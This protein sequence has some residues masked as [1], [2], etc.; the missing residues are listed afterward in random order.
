MRASRTARLRA[1]QEAKYTKGLFH[2]ELFGGKA[3]KAPSLT[4]GSK[5]KSRAQSKPDKD[6]IVLEYAQSVHEC[7][8]DFPYGFGQSIMKRLNKKVLS[9]T[10][11][12]P[13]VSFRGKKG[14]NMVTL[15]HKWLGLDKRPDDLEKVAVTLS[16]Y[17]NNLFKVKQQAQTADAAAATIWLQ[18]G[19]KETFLSFFDKEVN[20]VSA[21]Q[22][23]SN[24]NVVQHALR[25]IQDKYNAR[26]NTKAP[27]K[28]GWWHRGPTALGDL[29]KAGLTGAGLT[30]TYKAPSVASMHQRANAA[31]QAWAAGQ[32]KST[33]QPGLAKKLMKKIEKN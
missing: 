29:V 30:K 9:E 33:K 27:K 25:S 23:V 17:Q 3:P 18:N 15:D 20:K 7:L 6:N 32:T 31:A 22:E 5:V 19:Q 14:R 11:G 2:S 1:T 12:S 28:K 21:A 8:D 4:A 26:G 13:I 24:D 10:K 16:A